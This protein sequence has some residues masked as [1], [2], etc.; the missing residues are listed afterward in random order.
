MH[1]DDDDEADDNL[2]LHRK[3]KD[4]EARVSKVERWQTYMMGAAAAAG[5]ICTLLLAI[6]SLVLP[7]LQGK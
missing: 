1:N 3:L 4:L 2:A 6:L 5:A 7:L